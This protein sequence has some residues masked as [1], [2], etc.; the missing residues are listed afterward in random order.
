MRALVPQ[1]YHRGGLLLAALPLIASRAAFGHERFIPHTPKEQLHEDFFHSLNPDMLSIGLRG[2][3]VMALLMVLWLL[4][5]PLADFIE[6]RL[7]RNLQGKPK[8]L[9]RLLACFLMDKPVEHPWFKAA[10]EWAMV[11]FLRCLALVLIFS[12]NRHALVIPSYPLTP[13]TLLPFQFAQVVL[14]A[15]ILTQTLL[16]LCGA[17]IFGLFLYQLVAF[18]WIIAL[19]MLPFLLVAGVYMSLPWDNWKRGMTTLDRRQIRW[20]RLI[21]GLGFFVLG[22]MKIY[23]C[24]LTVGVADNF[25]AVMDDPLIKLFYVGTTALYQR[26][27][28]IVAF[29]MAEVMTGFLLMAG[30][31]C[32]VWCLLLVFMFTKLM[33]VDFGWAEI[34]HLYYIGLFLVLLFSNQLTDEFA[35][36]DAQTARAA[37]EGKS[38]RML[39]IALGS[40]SFFAALVVFS[41]LYVL[42]RFPHPALL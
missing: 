26:E 27:C 20:I 10:G 34:P 22:W 42:T 25:P 16:P 40:A 17:M 38:R 9:L 11:F 21:M 36:I 37:R 13:A 7:L 14:A 6:H 24:Y 28:W 31:F 3:I 29:G 2:A 15:G 8:E 33:V 39:L 19:D 1:L 41:G 4:R 12:A 18:D 23:D 35:G 5:Q 30:A 32:R